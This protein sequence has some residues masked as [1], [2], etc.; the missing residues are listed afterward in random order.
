MYENHRTPFG[1]ER[2]NSIPFPSP[3]VERIPVSLRIPPSSPARYRAI[4][5]AIKSRAVMPRDSS[6]LIPDTCSIA[7]LRWTIFPDPSMRRRPSGRRSSNPPVMA[8]SPGAVSL[9]RGVLLVKPA[10]MLICAEENHKLSTSRLGGSH[11]FLSR[12]AAGALH[13]F[14]LPFRLSVGGQSCGL[15]A[16]SDLVGT[17]RLWFHP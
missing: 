17:A 9:S 1:P 7:E 12:P 5:F 16:H 15:Q 3:P 14:S 6:A 2:A 8:S 11:M 13:P 4:P 10:P